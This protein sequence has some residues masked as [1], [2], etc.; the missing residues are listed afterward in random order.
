[1]PEVLAWLTR[2]WHWTVWYCG[3]QIRQRIVNNTRRSPCQPN[4]QNFFF[5]Q[6]CTGV[7][8][9]GSYSD[10][11]INLLTI[12][13]WHEILDLF[14][15]KSNQNKHN[16]ATREIRQLSANQTEPGKTKMLRFSQWESISQVGRALPR[17]FFIAFYFNIQTVLGVVEI[18]TEEMFTVC[19]IFCEY[20]QLNSH[21]TD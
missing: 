21:H 10:V 12:S 9:C 6:N 19:C 13:H 11:L 4:I 16:I 8:C 3:R 15:S 14:I 5:Y 1:M 7:G 2:Q 18:R 20:L 17:L